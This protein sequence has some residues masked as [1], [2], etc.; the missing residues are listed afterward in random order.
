MFQRLACA[1]SLAG[2]AISVAAALSGWTACD[3]ADVARCGGVG[4][5]QHLPDGDYCVYD[6]ARS[7]R[8]RDDVVCEGETPYRIVTRDAVVC[9]SRPAQPEELPSAVCER[10]TDRCLP[11]AEPDGGTDDSG[12]P[13]AGTPDTGSRDGARPDA[14]G[15]DA[16]TSG[17][18]RYSVTVLRA[19]APYESVVYLVDAADSATPRDVSAELDAALGPYDGVGEASLSL[20]WNGEWAALEGGRGCEAR[21]SAECVMVA[22]ADDLTRAVTLIGTDD[23]P[24]LGLTPQVGNDGALIVFAV[25]N[26]AGARVAE[27][28]PDGRWATRSLTTGSPYAY[29]AHPVLSADERHVAMRCGDQPYSEANICEVELDGSG[30][31]LRI[32][33]FDHPTAAEGPELD[34]PRYAPDGSIVFAARWGGVSQVWRSPEGERPVRLTTPEEAEWSPCVLPDGRVAVIAVPDAGEVRVR[35]PDG[36]LLFQ[37]PPLPLFD[38]YYTFVGGCGP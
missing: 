1:R 22:P 21:S 38:D 31:H 36:S 10:L 29:H 16:G 28:Q 14:V 20:S 4:V 11:P 5:Y 19:S 23:L 6:L 37:Q 12:A 25:P 26:N 7:G 15:P 13:D 30:F 33:R 34:W 24:V 9:A 3:S 27:R 35:A 18:G 17:A 8:T 32:D 2:V